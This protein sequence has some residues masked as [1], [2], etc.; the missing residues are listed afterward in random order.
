MT[1]LL[2]LKQDDR[3]LEIGTGSGYAAAILSQIVD[4]VY[5]VERHRSLADE[6]KE[7]FRQMGY[8]NIYVRHGD[9]TLGWPEYANATDA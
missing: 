1:E 2:E 4:E 8:D 6:A 5:T 3:I 9:G 7:K